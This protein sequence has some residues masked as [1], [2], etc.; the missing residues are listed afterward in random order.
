MALC[1]KLLNNNL[2]V[3]V[4]VL[5]IIFHVILGNFIAYDSSDV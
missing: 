4:D 3:T 1:C 5:E 2:V